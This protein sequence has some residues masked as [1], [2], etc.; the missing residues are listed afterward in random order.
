L[1]AILLGRFF[2]DGFESLSDRLKTRGQLLIP[3][4][5]FAF[6]LSYIGA[7]IRLEAILG[8]FAAGLILDETDK[9]RELERQVQPIA[10]MLVPIFFV[11]VGARTDFS[12]LNPTIP[13]N[14]EGLVQAIFLIS[15]AILGKVVTG[16]AVFGQPNIN[17]L[18]IGVGMIP[19][20]EV[21]LIFVSVGSASGVLSK[22]TEAA[23]IMMVIITTFL[24][25]PFL[26]VVFGKSEVEASAAVT[27]ASEQ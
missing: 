13:T 17:R 10:D 24:A 6:V 22:P 18:A 4:L 1:G 27:P 23:I 14:R 9:R 2:N 20:G 16:L 26:R 7:A 25:P 21:G 19:R 11:T 8:A 3:A 12:V 15:V 5:A